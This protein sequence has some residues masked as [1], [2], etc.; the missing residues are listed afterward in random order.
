MRKMAPIVNKYITIN[1][2]K[3]FK[4]MCVKN[5]INSLRESLKPSDCL[6]IAVFASLKRAVPWTQ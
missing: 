1:V 5:Q 2:A 3:I 6:K 4:I